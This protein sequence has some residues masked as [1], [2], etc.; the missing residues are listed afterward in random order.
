MTVARPMRFQLLFPISYCSPRSGKRLRLELLS[1][2]DS[3]LACH[4][5]LLEIVN[6]L[7]DLHGSQLWCRGNVPARSRCLVLSA[8]TARRNCRTI[9]ESPYELFRAGDVWLNTLSSGLAAGGTVTLPVTISLTLIS[10]P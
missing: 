5:P 7:P 4:S 10:L 9:L 3:R 1:D 2:V 8:A 6:P